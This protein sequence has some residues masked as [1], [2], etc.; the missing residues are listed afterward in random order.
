M[1]RARRFV[2][3]LAAA[4][5]AAA[6]AFPAQAREL[7]LL[8]GVSAYDEPAIRSLEG[9][10][11]DVAL[12][13][14]HLT[15]R[16]VAPADIE[17]LAEP[18]PDGAAP[19]PAAA[20]TR[21]AILA[22]LAGLAARARTGD[23]VFIHYSG[24]GSTQPE[25]ALAEGAQPEPG[26]RVQV[27][28]PKDAG[29]YDEAARTIRNALVDKEIG[30]A[31]DRIRETG[32]RLFVVIDACHA[33]T[34]TRAGAGTPRSV[35][36]AALGTPEAAPDAPHP[37]APTR[38]ATLKRDPSGALIGF[39]AVDAWSEALERPFPVADGTGGETRRTHGAFT[40]HLV[41]ALE[42][43]RAKSYR[44]L[45][46]LVALDMTRAAASLPAPMF[47]GD[48]D[49]ALPG[50][51]TQAG[52]PLFPARIDG[53]EAIVEAGRL[54]GVEAGARLALRDGPLA[55]ARRLAFATVS[56]AGPATSRA[57]VEGGAPDAA[58][59][60][61]ASLEAPGVAFRLRVAARG[62]AVAPIAAAARDLP[63]DLV[64]G[65]ADIQADVADSRVWIARDGAAIERDPAS[66]R[67]AASVALA[68]GEG[69]RALLWRFAR[70]GNLIRLAAASETQEAGESG[71]RVALTL[72]RETDPSRLADPRRRC[73]APARA[74]DSAVEAD[75][76]QAMGH[77][78]GLRLT[79][80]NTSERDLDVGVFFVDPAAEIAIPSREWR[81]NGC[82]AYL[83]ARA[84][85]PL[86]V[87]TQARLWTQEGPGLSGL[88]DV[89]VFAL[90]RREGMPVDLCP[91][92][93]AAP[94]A[95]APLRA[96]RRGF[97]DLLQR[98]GL[99]DPGLR[100]ANPFAG[101]DETAQA[102]V[103]MRRYVLDLRPAGR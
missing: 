32:A 100:A 80:E 40:W 23:E 37:A 18:A 102:G 92:I 62:A 84:G 10:R 76:T 88:H 7:A 72:T 82:V 29:R 47:E 90:P 6:T 74:A 28:L 86:V 39:F 33:G 45:A 95:V 59:P 35:D 78:D 91:L 93:A 5:L 103:T 60:L 97:A 14:R 58:G 63:V 81:N 46:R 70:A 19:V 41:R 94:P 27:L 15:A 34:V 48:L 56:E 54:Q 55:D 26:G 73:A 4:L 30:A 68:D 66:P 44:D 12:L 85:R 51:E 24:H 17:V 98:A 89:L 1:T 57:A 2:P 77:C 49:R 38:R 36:P 3:M 61:W 22:A 53:A 87:R 13:W 67:R 9:P 101:E 16:G 69:L 31:L 25:G 20:P 65:P 75:M 96:G 11:N 71:A 83:P 8:I 52:A 64:E 99:A 79:I 21:A 43:G 42:Q 50:V